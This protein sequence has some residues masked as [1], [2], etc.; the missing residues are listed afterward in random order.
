MTSWEIDF[1]KCPYG[2]PEI[3]DS[4]CYQGDMISRGDSCLESKLG[5]VRTWIKFH[6]ASISAGNKG[7][8][9]RVKGSL[10]EACV[11]TE[12]L[13]GSMIWAS[14]AEGLCRLEKNEVN[15][16]QLV[17]NISVHER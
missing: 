6:G 2:S 5:K 16:F 11:K 1:L 17:C 15:M 8:S 4:F 10:C 7:F 12:L 3:V 13:Y 14:D 9:H